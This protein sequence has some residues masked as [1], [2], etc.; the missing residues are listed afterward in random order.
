MEQILWKKKKS[1][2][3]DKYN[4][5]RFLDFHMITFTILELLVT[6]RHLMLLRNDIMARKNVDV[7]TFSMYSWFLPSLN[8][9]SLR[10][11]LIGP[12]ELS[13]RSEEDYGDTNP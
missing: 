9:V 3:C 12:L 1:P 8:E 6:D 2:N 13:L 10:T 11:S 7:A 4:D 5:F